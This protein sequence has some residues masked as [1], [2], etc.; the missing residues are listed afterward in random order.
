[1]N[2]LYPT[3][4]F[5]DFVKL[6]P[7]RGQE[8]TRWKRGGKWEYLHNFQRRKYCCIPCFQRGRISKTPT[9]GTLLWRARK[10]RGSKCEACGMQLELQAHHV[11]G[12]QN[13]NQKNNIQTLCLWC[14]KFLHDTADRLGKVE[15]GKLPFLGL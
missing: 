9:K 1:M 3:N 13:D 11:N 10:F 8:F 2:E 14:H 5:V 4:N 6:C 12:A 7:E 15:P